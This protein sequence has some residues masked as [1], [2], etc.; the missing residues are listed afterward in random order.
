[1]SV[2]NQSVFQESII[3]REQVCEEEVQNVENF[4]ESINTMCEEVYTI[5]QKLGKLRTVL[6]RN[7]EFL[8]KLLFMISKQINSFLL[9]YYNVLQVLHFGKPE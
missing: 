1:M 3:E 6:E 4:Q 7:L 2:S 9:N 5:D 8:I